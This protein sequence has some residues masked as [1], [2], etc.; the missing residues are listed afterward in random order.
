[1]RTAEARA[2]EQRSSSTR[3]SRWKQRCGLDV[4]RKTGGGG[5]PALM[6]SQQVKSATELQ[7]PEVRAES[8]RC[9]RECERKCFASS[10]LGSIPQAG[11]RAR[12]QATHEQIEGQWCERSTGTVCRRCDRARRS[13]RKLC[14]CA[15]RVLVAHVHEQ[16][17]FNSCAE[18]S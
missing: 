1:V 14:G 16:K 17:K 2:R 5:K 18:K 15:G 4:Q 3:R 13:C 10:R 11:A 12:Q 6:A 7:N 9:V 8:N